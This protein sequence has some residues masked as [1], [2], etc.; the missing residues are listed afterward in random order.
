MATT[1][2]FSSTNTF[3]ANDGVT[4]RTSNWSSTF[5]NLA[6]P[7]GA[8]VNGLK[9]TLR[10]AKGS[11]EEDI[12]GAHFKVISDTDSDVISDGK[13][14]NEESGEVA[15]FTDYSDITVG[16]SNDLWGLDWTVAQANGVTLQFNMEFVEGAEFTTYWDSFQ[17]E[18]TYTAAAVAGAGKIIVKQG[19][20][21]LKQ[22]KITL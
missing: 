4:S 1:S 10:V 21:T 19:I 12:S 9:F 3:S 18:I 14:I 5:S 20:I 15:T 11:E 16:A 22:G 13:G 6:V 7:A 8:T 2:G 17:C